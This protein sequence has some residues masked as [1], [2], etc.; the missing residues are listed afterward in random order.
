MVSQLAAIVHAIFLSKLGVDSPAHL[1][2][3]YLVLK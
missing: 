2:V 1:T 3:S